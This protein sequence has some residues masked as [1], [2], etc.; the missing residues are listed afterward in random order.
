MK[1]R[2]AMP[3][4]T[5]SFTQAEK[6]RIEKAM[7]SCDGWAEGDSAIFART[8]LLRCVASIPREVKPRKLLRPGDRLRARLQYLS[9][10]RRSGLPGIVFPQKDR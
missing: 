3:I 7:K 9:C 8:V 1:T 4:L 10:D 5:L 6:A 2:R